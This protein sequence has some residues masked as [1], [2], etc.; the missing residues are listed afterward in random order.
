MVNKTDEEMAGLVDT[1]DL[2]IEAT[3]TYEKWQQALSEELG[4][5]FS[6]IV[7]ERTWKGVEVLHESLPAVGLAYRRVEQKWGYQ[8]QYISVD[9]SLTGQRVG[10]VVSFEK[11]QELRGGL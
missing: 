1:L 3:S 4:L 10:T 5:R 6:D 7:A 9:A 8:S 11:V 2:P